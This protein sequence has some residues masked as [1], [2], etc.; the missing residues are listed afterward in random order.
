MTGAAPTRAQ[1]A[2]SSTNGNGAVG[3]QGSSKDHRDGP[4]P[5]KKV[6]VRRLTRSLSLRLAA[7]FGS[8]GAGGS[9]GKLGVS[10]LQV[11]ARST[12]LVED[13]RAEAELQEAKGPV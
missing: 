11:S 2:E 1:P 4:P 3:E 7:D 8:P 6:K 5:A 10:Y 12:Q 13:E 9:E